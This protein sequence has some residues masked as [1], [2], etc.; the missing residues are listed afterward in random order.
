M[1]T[2]EHV[3]NERVR[4]QCTL[5]R[6]FTVETEIQQINSNVS[7]NL[8]EHLFIRFVFQLF[9]VDFPLAHRQTNAMKSTL[10]VL[11]GRSDA[12][13][14]RTFGQV[15]Q[16]QRSDK[17]DKRIL[18]VSRTGTSVDDRQRQRQRRAMCVAFVSLEEIS[19]NAAIIDRLFIGAAVDIIV[20]RRRRRRRTDHIRSI[21][22]QGSHRARLVQRR[23]TQQFAVCLSSWKII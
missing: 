5:L 20:R 1:F 16:Q 8:V 13:Q 10:K 21:H 7:I 9:V 22:R 2:S 4:R 19:T 6:S 14:Q 23:W 15:T 11:F 3:T 17:T 12:E 18:I